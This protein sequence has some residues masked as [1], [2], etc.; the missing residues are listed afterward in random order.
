MMS[1]IGEE[2]VTSA[3]LRRALL[4]LGVVLCV[5][6]AGGICVGPAMAAGF[7]LT[8]T[9]P[10]PDMAS[11]PGDQFGQAVAL[12]GDTMIVGAP[13]DGASGTASIYTQDSA[14]VWTYDQ[15][16]TPSPVD[17]AYQFGESVAI[18]GGAIVV[19][20]PGNSNSYSGSAWVYTQDSS[21]TW[22]PQML[23]PIPNVN[24]SIESD[25]G[26]SVAISSDGDTI[27]VG[28]PEEEGCPTIHCGAVF[29]YTGSPTTGFSPDGTIDSPDDFVNLFGSAVAISG[30]TVFVGEPQLQIGQ[31][32][33]A[34]AVYGYTAGAG[35]DWGAATQT[36]DLT[37]TTQGGGFGDALAAQGSTLVVG[38]PG[39]GEQG[40]SG[41]VG[42]GFVYDVSAAGAATVDSELQPALSSGS[43]DPEYGT[44]VAVD[45]SSVVLGPYG[46]DDPCL[47]SDASGSTGVCQALPEVNAGG[48]GGVA[49]SGATIAV[50]NAYAGTPPEGAVEIFSQPPP[51]VGVGPPPTAPPSPVIGSGGAGGAGTD[52]GTG[53]AGGTGGG[54][55][56]TGGS[57]PSKLPPP[58]RLLTGLKS[59][60]GKLATI[61]AI[62]THRSYGLRYRAVA[63][64]VLTDAWYA[65]V[66]HKRVLVAAGSLPIRRAESVTLK[67]KLTTAGRV[68]LERSAKLKLRFE[69]SFTPTGGKAL[70]AGGSFTLR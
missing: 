34:G 42:A 62:L 58:E 43:T 55:G 61:K 17:E 21:G 14:G 48:G 20:A 4:A 22:T 38:A 68:L 57:P 24:S 29:M 67:L 26:Q 37:A 18:S 16:L 25:V 40:V 2:R 39:V 51:T 50:G 32:S 53:G 41:P 12:S 31:D 3:G 30:Q 66:G 60:A 52:G 8:Q 47:F 65:D 27:A 44:T 5:M 9:L 15:T 1:T 11:S 10:S 46:T 49:V 45:G 6:L 54:T 59:P 13:G 70:T 7:G 33:Q 64:G 35:A 23:V 56:G 36:A 69:A 19:G 28:A 63:A